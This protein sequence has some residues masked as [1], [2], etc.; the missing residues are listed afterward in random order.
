MC[1]DCSSSLALGRNGSRAEVG[2]RSTEECADPAQDVDR[3]QHG[4]LHRS[5]AAVAVITETGAWKVTVV[6][7]ITA[8][9]IKSL[10]TVFYQWYFVSQ[11]RHQQTALSARM[12]S[13]LSTTSG[14]NY[15]Q[16]LL[17]NK[18]HFH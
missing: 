6:Q 9:E 13:M 14:T 10:S 15:V 17:K 16:L 12:S 8:L 2:G 3:R 4:G 5:E 1:Q 7:V 18:A 11:A